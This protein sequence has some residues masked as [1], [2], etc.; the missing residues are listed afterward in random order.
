MTRDMKET[1]PTIQIPSGRETASPTA[2]PR[3]GGVWEVDGEKI[4]T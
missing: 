3:S 1:D 4:M 2:S